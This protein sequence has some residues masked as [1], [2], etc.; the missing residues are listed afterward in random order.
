MPPKR[1]AKKQDATDAINTADESSP[2][3]R[4]PLRKRPKVEGEDEEANAESKDSAEVAVAV[5]E[6]VI[7]DMESGAMGAPQVTGNT[8][9]EEEYQDNGDIDDEDESGSSNK[10]RTYRSFQERFN[11]LL[12]FKEIHGHT[13]VPKRYPADPSLGQWVS[14]IRSAKNRSEIGSDSAASASF[15]LSEEH[16]QQ[17]DGIGFKWQLEKPGKQFHEYFADLLEYKKN[18]GNVD[19]PTNFPEDPSLGHWVNRI[20]QSY[21]VIS[22]GER[23][24][25]PLSEE[26]I[27]QL[28]SIGFKFTVRGHQ[29]KFK[30]FE[31]RVEELMEYASVHGDVNVPK[32]YKDNVPLARW[33]DKIRTSYRDQKEGKKTA[34]RYELTDD[35]IQQLEQMGFKWNFGA[36]RS[37]AVPFETR[38]EGLLRFKEAHGHCD[39]PAN[40]KEERG[41]G[42]WCNNIRVAYKNL[43]VG[44]QGTYKLTQDQI[45]RLE[46]IGF[47]WAVTQSFVNTF[48]E[49][50]AA[51]IE[52]KKVHGHCD[53]PAQKTALGRWCNQVRVSFK[54]KGS[55]NRKRPYHLTQ[56]QIDRLS[57]IG[58]KWQV[59]SWHTS[60]DRR[61]EELKEYTNKH[62]HCYVP[63]KYADNLSLGYWCN[64]IRFAYKC[65]KEGKPPPSK[66]T[67]EQIVRLD[68]INFEWVPLSAKARMSIGPQN[69][70]VEQFQN[71]KQEGAEDSVLAAVEALADAATGTDDSVKV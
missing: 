18:H 67:P 64:N 56:D 5:A 13:N 24:Y 25:N 6:A 59:G 58:F 55:A 49:R 66:L 2:S 50:I 10:R 37:R 62:G 15:S 46:E 11:D 23:P 42:H 1:R 7:Q 28:N 38:I 44:K 60:F 22:E 21:R 30:S 26:Q 9:D 63:P 12:A 14:H 69:V 31:E 40:F 47:K 45:T 54:A 51:L 39:V 71:A 53:V 43:Q 8:V 57:E 19:V 17:L 70:H 29:A 41:L 36:V 52:F 16:V 61:I 34:R 33:C 27:E 32:T 68:E 20:R 4:L 35:Q 48:D 3:K 65:I